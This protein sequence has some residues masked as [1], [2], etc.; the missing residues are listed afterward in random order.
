[1]AIRTFVWLPGEWQT[2]NGETE[3]L[4]KTFTKEN[5]EEKQDGEK[6]VGS[7][8]KLTARKSAPPTLAPTEHDQPLKIA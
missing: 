3:R 2:A 1:M 4:R 6:S 8:R 7:K 5:A